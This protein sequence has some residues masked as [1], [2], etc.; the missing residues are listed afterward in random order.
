MNAKKISR[1]SIP[2]LF[3]FSL[4]ALGAAAVFA[5]TEGGSA[6]PTP[7]GPNL[8][9][10]PTAG[11]LPIPLLPSEIDPKTVANFDAAVAG[12]KP[13]PNDIDLTVDVVGLDIRAGSSEEKQ[14]NEVAAAGAGKY[15]GVADAA[16]LAGVFA[17]VAA[18]TTAPAPSGGGGGGMVLPKAGLSTLAVGAIALGFLCLALLAGVLIVRNRRAGA[19]EAAP[20]G[21]KIRA[22]VDI[23]LPD[24]RQSAYEIRT[25]VTSIGR[26]GDNAIVLDDDQ[27]SGH[28]AEIY[29]GREGFR[30]RDV[31]SSNG[32]FLRGEQ[33]ED[34][35]FYAGDEVTVGSTRIVLGG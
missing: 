21:E 6:P 25:Q 4:L 28:H 23:I 12:M 32:T 20:A 5:Q 27:I 26:A 10:R 29:A 13:V 24:G 8:K 19:P 7:K 9:P 30:I 35:A 33:I 1:I 15:Y 18:G 34:S 3:V 31:G 11:V 2:T 16:K 22:R 14:L 17:Q